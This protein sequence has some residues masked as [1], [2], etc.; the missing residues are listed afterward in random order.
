MGSITRTIKGKLKKAEGRMTG[1]KVREAQGAV[2]EKA[3]SFGTKVKGNVAKAK[4][5]I[6]EAKTKAKIKAA[7]TKAGRKA[8]A[9][10][11]MP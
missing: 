8:G 6:A 3:G 10:K 7:K 1:D 4:A 11:A 5:K 2:E 9:A